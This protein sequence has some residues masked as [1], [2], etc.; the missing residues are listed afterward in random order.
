MLVRQEVS[1]SQV[2][3]PGN[4]RLFQQLPSDC[5]CR[6]FPIKRRGSREGNQKSLWRIA[7]PLPLSTIDVERK[8]NPLNRRANCIF[9]GSAAPLKSLANRR[10][11]PAARSDF[12]QWL[13]TGTVA[14]PYQ[15]LCPRKTPGQLTSHLGESLFEIDTKIYPTS[16]QTKQ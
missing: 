12:R 15:M 2:P 10:L 14:G 3:L 7:P 8:L 4:G 9:S 13:R 11:S 6:G 5:R 16:G 1:E